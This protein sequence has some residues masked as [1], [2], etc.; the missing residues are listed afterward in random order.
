MGRMVHFYLRGCDYYHGATAFL[1]TVKSRGTLKWERW[2][3]HLTHWND[4]LNFFF[5]EQL[6]MQMAELMVSDGWR[7]AGYDY[8]CIDDCWMAPE[9]DSKGRLQADRSQSFSSC[10]CTWLTK[11][12]TLATLTALKQTPGIWPTTWP[13]DQFQHHFPH[14]S[15]NS[16]HWA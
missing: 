15:S 7:D 13:L 4:C 6:F 1:E 14:W 10:L 9:R 12:V 16:H 11:R 5:S 3:S 2:S 8:L